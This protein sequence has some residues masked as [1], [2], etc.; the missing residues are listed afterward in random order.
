[1]KKENNN[2]MNLQQTASTFETLLNIIWHQN[3]CIVKM[4]QMTQI[5]NLQSHVYQRINNKKKTTFFW[6]FTFMTSNIRTFHVRCIIYV[7]YMSCL[8]FFFPIFLYRRHK[9]P[10]KIAVWDFINAIF[11]LLILFEM[12]W[13]CC[14]D[15]VFNL[16]FLFF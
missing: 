11:F 10:D 12:E 13:K 4:S 9:T 2:Y 15:V 5:P 14:P 7:A 6:Q 1:M 3:S 16:K 8:I